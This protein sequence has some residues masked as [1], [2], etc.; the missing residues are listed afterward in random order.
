MQ[1]LDNFLPYNLNVYMFFINKQTKKYFFLLTIIIFGVF[2]FFG[3]IAFAQVAEQGGVDSFGLSYG[4]S[5]GL[6]TTDIR[7]TIAK[8][9]RAAFGLLGIVA[10]GLMIYG[11]YTYMTAA[12]D[13][14]KIT[15]ARK[16]LINSVIGLAI[17]LSAFS[18]T[19]FVLNKLADATGF[20][21]GRANQ[22][23]LCADPIFANEHRDICDDFGGF[24][25]G[26]DNCRL[27]H[28]VVESITPNT[29]ATNI[30]DTKVRVLFSRN[31]NNDDSSTVINIFRNGQNINAEFEY[32]FLAGKRIIEAQY[33]GPNMCG[34]VKCL[35]KG[36]F[37]T[38]VRPDI[39]DEQGGA[40]EIAPE[41]CDEREF[42]MRAEFIVN[43]ENILDDND[44]I[45]SNIRVFNSQN[46][47]AAEEPD[48]WLPKGRKYPIMA[49]IV[50][51]AGFAY[52]RLE[53]Q[54]DG[55]DENLINI[56]EGPSIERGSDAVVDNSYEFRYDF[57]IPA[58]AEEMTRYIVRLTSYDIDGK[59]TLKTTSFVVIG[60]NCDPNGQI[61]QEGC[62]VDGGICRDD[63]QCPSRR[64]VEGI[65]VV[66]SP[67][68]L[69]VDPW[70]AGA[71]N[72]IT[73]A[74]I[75]FG[76]VP[77]SV[78]FKINGTDDWLHSD[79]A[80]CPGSVSWTN[81]YAIVS[82]PTDIDLPLDSESSIRIIKNGADGDENFIDSTIDDFGPKPGPKNGLFTK[83][84]ESYPGIC[85]VQPDEVL[86][87]ESVNISGIR[88]GNIL[89]QNQ[90][91]FGDVPGVI[92][93]AGNWTNTL[94][95]S[96]VNANMQP[97]IV[98]AR[99]IMEGG[100]R[101]NGVPLTILNR[102]D[103]ELPQVISVEPK[104][105]TK[106]SLVTIT[107]KN[108]GDSRGIV[109]LANNAGENCRETQACEILGFLDEPIACSN[110]AW[111]DNQIIAYV[112]KNGTIQ[113][114]EYTIIIEDSQNSAKYSIEDVK[115]NI[116]DGDVLP[117]ICALSP[118][119]GPAPLLDGHP[120]LSITGINLENVG[121]VLFWGRNSIDTGIV[122]DYMR[123]WLVSVLNNDN[124]SQ[125]NTVIKTRISVARNGFSMPEGT[126]PIRVRSAARGVSNPLYYT[127]QDCT[128]LDELPEG[129][130]CCESEAGSGILQEDN[131]ACPGE[132]REA[133]YMWRFSSGKIPNPPRV[134]ESCDIPSPSPSTMFGADN[135]CLNAVITVG[136]STNMD[137]QSF[138]GGLHVYHCGNGDIRNCDYTSDK[139]NEFRLQSQSLGEAGHVVRLVKDNGNLDPNIW[140]RVVVD[141]TLA[142]REVELVV[143]EE[144]RISQKIV[145]TKRL[146][147]VPNAA[148]YFDFKTGNIDAGPNGDGLC[149][150][151]G[152]RIRPRSYITELLG[153]LYYPVTSDDPMYHYISGS[154]DQE[155]IELDVD[156]LDWTWTTG[157]NSLARVEK[158]I[159]EE[160]ANTR[161]HV[162]ALG[163]SFAQ[164]V[165]INVSVDEINATAGIIIA[166]AEPKVKNYEPHCNASCVNASIGID[167]N[168]PMASTRYTTTEGFV[169][170]C[171]DDNCYKE[172][173]AIYEC[174]DAN[175][176]DVELIS[177]D[178]YVFSSIAERSFTVALE[179]N[180][181]KNTYYKVELNGEDAGRHI[182]SL[183]KLDPPIEGKLLE[184]FNWSFRTKNDETPCEINEVTLSP[185]DFVARTIG[186]QAVY[187]VMAKSSPNECS[188][189]GQI[190]DP[191]KYG[192]IWRSDNS[193]IASV[194][195]FNTFE[196][197]TYCSDICLPNGSDILR[198]TY[199]NVDELLLCGNGVVDIGED[200]DI[201]MGGEI[202]HGTCS[203]NC[204]RIGNED[205]G[206]N[207]GQCG[208]NELD[209]SEQCDPGVDAEG[210][211]VQNNPFCTS[212]CLFR[213]SRVLSGAEESQA[214]AVDAD[215][216]K[217]F[218]SV[219]GNGQLEKK[220][221]ACDDGNSRNGDGCSNIC[222][223][224]G[225]QISATWCERDAVREIKEGIACRDSVSV[226]G[227]GIV[228]QGE[229]CEIGID[230]ATN[231]NCN[232]RCT[233]ELVCGTNLAQCSVGQA[234]CGSDCTYNGSSLE[235]GTP[236][237]CGDGIVG[238]GEMAS[239]EI[240]LASVEDINPGSNPV[241]I[242]T[243]V[244]QGALENDDQKTIIHVSKANIRNNDIVESEKTDEG[245]F[246]LSCGYKEF[247]EKKSILEDGN[248]LEDGF[249]VG[250]SETLIYNGDFELDLSINADR[251][252]GQ[253]FDGINFEEF[254]ILERERPELG[255]N[256]YI[257][258]VEDAR[259]GG[260]KQNIGLLEKG[261][262]LVTFVYKNL[263]NSEA[264]LFFA[265]EDHL[266]QRTSIDLENIQEWSEFSNIFNIENDLENV[267][268]HIGITNGGMYIDDI[269]VKKIVQSEL[270][271]NN[272]PNNI[273]N[274]DGVG[275]NSCCYS[276]S[277]RESSS[278]DDG[279]GLS[280]G[281]TV[282]RNTRM[283]V[284]FDKKIDQETLKNN[285]ILARGYEDEA[286]DCTVSNEFDISSVVK[287]TL[288]FADI[289]NTEQGFFGRIWIAFIDFIKR[290]FA[291]ETYASIVQN[292]NIKTWC[293]GSVGVS[294]EAIHEM[295]A[296]DTEYTRLV[297]S[298]DG[299]LES[300]TV[301]TLFIKG[302]ADGIKDNRG[303]G[304]AGKE[305]FEGIHAKDDS[306]MF[307]TT[308]DICRIATIE[309][310][311]SDYVFT[312]A[313]EEK[314]FIARAYTRNGRPISSVP[315]YSWDWNWGP[316]ASEI[317]AIP[318]NSDNPVNEENIT[319]ASKNIEGE[320]FVV[321]NAVIT[322]S[323]AIDES[324]DGIAY[325]AFA[326]L[327]S[328]F[329]ANPWPRVENYPY[330]NDF[331]NFKM[332]YCA[333]NNDRTTTD[334]DF[335]YLLSPVISGV[336]GDITGDG[337]I[338]KADVD[339]Y[340]L[341]SVND[342]ASCIDNIIEY[343]DLNCDGNIT[344]LDYASIVT[345][346]KTRWFSNIDADNNLVPDCKEGIRKTDQVGRWIFFNDK[347]EDIIGM[348]IFS[349]EAGTEAWQWYGER[350]DNIGEYQRISI[351]GYDAITNGVNY[352]IH[353]SNIHVTEDVQGKKITNISDFI[354]H[355]SVNERSRSKTREVLEKLLA[356]LEFN[357]NITDFGYCATSDP[358]PGI[359]PLEQP[360]TDPLVACSSDFD[361]TDP[362]GFPKEN[363]LSGKCSNT[364][365]RIFR[366]IKRIDD[367]ADIQYKISLYNKAPELGAG[368]FIPG[369]SNSIWPSWT[370]KLAAEISE[371]FLQK[372]A[373]NNWSTCGICNNSNIGCVSDE[374]CNTGENDSCQILDAQ[375]CWSGEKNLFV[376]P[377]KSQMFEYVYHPDNKT[378][379]I[380]APL[381][382]FNIGDTIVNDLLDIEKYSI[383][384]SCIPMQ[385]QNP[386]SEVCGD[387]IVNATRGEEC[388]PPGQTS[389][390]DF[391]VLP[392]SSAVGHCQ[393]SGNICGNDID[394]GYIG[395]L[396]YNWD[397][398]VT[399]QQSGYCAMNV[400]G[401]DNRDKPPRASIGIGLEPI[402]GETVQLISCSIDANCFKSRSK[403]YEN[404]ENVFLWDHVED[405]SVFSGT[406]ERM[407]DNFGEF[408]FDQQNLLGT[409]FC[410]KE[411]N[412]LEGLSC[413]GVGDP[414]VGNCRENGF[415]SA[416]RVCNDSCQWEEP[417][418]CQNFAECGNGVVEQGEFCDD[419]VLNGTYGHC[420]G[421]D[422]FEVNECK[423][424]HPQ[425]CGNNELDYID[426][427]NNG[428][429]DDGENTP[430][431][432]CDSTAT[433]TVW[434]NDGN[435][436]ISRWWSYHIE[437]EKSCAS[438]CQTSG[439]YC[440]DGIIQFENEDCDDSNDIVGDGCSNFCQSENNECVQDLNPEQIIRTY[441]AFEDNQ[442]HPN[443]NEMFTEFYIKKD[444]IATESCFENTTASALCG[445]FG[446]SCIEG[447]TIGDLGCN[448]D[449]SSYAVTGMIPG[450]RPYGVCHNTVM[451]CSNSLDCGFVGK[452]G[453][454]LIKSSKIGYYAM[455]D[456]DEDIAYVL[457]SALL[458]ED[459][460]SLEDGKITSRDNNFTLEDFV[461]NNVDTGINVIECVEGIDMDIKVIQDLYENIEENNRRVFFL[462]HKN[463]GDILGYWGYN[464][465]YD[466]DKNKI[467]CK[468]EKNGLE[469]NHCDGGHDE[470]VRL[471]CLGEYSDFVEPIV[472]QVISEC[473]NGIV[474]EDIGEVCDLAD[475]NGLTCT[476]EYGNSCF[477][478]SAE[479]NQI[480]TV[481]P[482]A[483]CGNGKIDQLENGEFEACDF[484]G[485]EVV[486]QGIP[487]GDIEALILNKHSISGISYYDTGDP[488]VCIDKGSYDCNRDCTQLIDNCIN[489]TICDATDPNSDCSG[490]APKLAVLNVLIP[491]ESDIN[492]DWGRNTRRDLIRR[493]RPDGFSGH[494]GDTI[495]WRDA[496][497]NYFEM[498][499]IIMDQDGPIRTQILE[500]NLACNGEY[501]VY[502]NEENMH[503]VVLENLDFGAFEQYGDFFNYP[504]NDERGVVEKEFILS[505]AVSEDT[506]RVVVHWTNTESNNKVNKFVGNL[507]Q[508]G[509][510][511]SNYM[512]FMSDDCLSSNIR[513]FGDSNRWIPFYLGAQINCTVE[514]NFDQRVQ[515]HPIGGLRRN[516]VQATTVK[517]LDN[518]GVGARR[519]AFYVGAVSNDSIPIAQFADSELKVE[520]YKHHDGQINQYS[521]YEPDQTF[522]IKQSTKSANNFAGYWHVF[523]FTVNDEGDPIVELMTDELGTIHDNGSIESCFT[524]ILCNLTKDGGACNQDNLP[525]MC[526]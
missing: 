185:K 301:Y 485:G 103:V 458:P 522:Y 163:D 109:Y 385:V 514:D 327:T 408:G 463:T 46:G 124:F 2:I 380:H 82:V 493:I 426:V 39:V 361:C 258:Y 55:E 144:Q 416:R 263:H 80:L 198:G 312:N 489:C 114:D 520:I 237:L 230:G 459:N 188:N 212:K 374:D 498:Q 61:E 67:V 98:D 236:S 113:F 187:R 523:N 37:V 269:V 341:A 162:E 69:D 41:N 403:S 306:I 438:N 346:N 78:E 209:L 141:N 179:N 202:P 429:R 344:R 307:K 75:N 226:C 101:S 183:N 90:V 184:K 56:Y 205:I 290:I 47:V 467:K 391:G 10:L 171:I 442:H 440:G 278:P 313:Q 481:D 322:D 247:S 363:G 262:Y 490:A 414:L 50:D 140:Y 343:T 404:I 336:Y 156:G 499:Y 64:C 254:A 12:G 154:A 433:K 424:I 142:S 299:I 99:V 153:L 423:G 411:N 145:S 231:N 352:Y 318:S 53:I 300:N 44:P 279:A 104:E 320:G 293:A 422:S 74:G 508:W 420:A 304:I 204:L 63:W 517:L 465:T 77:G 133:G 417:G 284:I 309:I 38:E 111:S 314:E 105:V 210:N 360:S 190:M 6:G 4:E 29:E 108:F 72:W 451:P 83:T 379:T 359:D 415:S 54:K 388:E 394:C 277:L 291:P 176:A 457:G 470:N 146:R 377:Q 365:T 182:R 127:V 338:D 65:C 454:Y 274:G 369:Y 194:T 462:W 59:S 340:G 71:D 249:A 62:P 13:E 480:I 85:G 393:S 43:T 30:N 181:E 166:I 206:I 512:D 265:S 49:S 218:E 288:A 3:D 515:F 199:D 25:G 164:E 335:P 106:G 330:Q 390:S 479:C 272:C 428:S 40:L 20:D 115:I 406:V 14:N 412:N 128:N 28:F 227:N 347:N 27:E 21:T 355:L 11:G 282:C 9:I 126:H 395:S 207:P 100:K 396:E 42:P 364:K 332:S 160:Y 371:S 177:K 323:T 271:Y 137:E 384:Q 328:R 310:E 401:D 255:R 57:R 461:H 24:G 217:I 158:K 175:C 93:Q 248:F 97:G 402:R 196:R 296:D 387:G 431:E 331:F 367:I 383:E 186:E 500:T 240:D 472:E 95:R 222:L 68:I 505:P 525:Q 513:M 399:S 257:D 381:E 351:A 169:V 264:N 484:V 315:G 349:D 107:G 102:S 413:E 407:H 496:F 419:G 34:D 325:S 487:L 242:V 445:A 510:K 92:E 161:A 138:A 245:N 501:S 447:N 516:F 294:V 473:G 178:R 511:N 139:I 132:V 443:N 281:D 308:E 504:V 497:I 518:V 509:G 122:R 334:D 250:G 219:C 319:I 120:D 452:I 321:V 435:F 129:Y 475:Q 31:V 400:V 174:F 444:G 192:W 492:L 8:I 213:G 243:A 303:V 229:E 273:N 149:E 386:F 329:C 157:D 425:F 81:N 116:I 35:A 1:L 436:T 159:G 112:P 252:W 70:S 432:F 283:E 356:S 430:L 168:I 468:T 348:Q 471:L 96:K 267:S 60:Q 143:G 221:E 486:Q 410:Y 172:G 118:T 439:G 418:L 136:F 526:R 125:N 502:F 280:N 117:S 32:N 134:L 23:Q 180:F 524:N 495:G 16:I 131:L 370:E 214:V 376:C 456:E 5:T 167:F 259:S 342:N 253:Y 36:N 173:L 350:Y 375:T 491:R 446:L 234:G 89:G 285:I 339:C 506:F 453:K 266:I 58:T 427:N 18:I 87:G 241:Q 208:N 7:V 45:V 448:E 220:G 203:T 228:E 86:S 19:Q 191:L 337:F 357:T 195:N 33:I 397:S 483:F 476:P 22:A 73:I 464:D 345:L 238:I 316:T 460:E 256:M 147:D 170:N 372:D 88:F 378:Y 66:G 398:T 302:G 409:P 366:D 287:G 246:T 450:Q 441:K 151:T 455:S 449:L 270:A 354:L 389:Y 482:E 324:Q 239:C 200:C 52:A 223:N 51:N 474:D 521:L 353:V 225:T 297:I 130:K 94:I 503:T 437:Q 392:Y 15:T 123:T 311:P 189:R 305:E 224:E 216:N 244:G 84:N 79:L 275:T 152:A 276:R 317:F 233:L 268:I 26:E 48:Q 289:D 477:Y 362:L 193:D 17:I 405:T 469:R 333:D 326:D 211:I 121:H 261:E 232:P 150:L 135:A 466:N 286:Y 434:D 165:G 119:N 494:L 519:Y 235:Y 382:Y 155:C 292:D 295:R 368:T 373:I 298:P 358:V 148:Y 201:A 251:N 421:P 215:G 488:L 110:F 197:N 478:C 507:Y 91:V 260:I 76:D